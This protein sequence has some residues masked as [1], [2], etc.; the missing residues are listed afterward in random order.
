LKP[1]IEEA[2]LYSTELRA[3]NDRDTKKISIYQSLQHS[4]N[5]FGKV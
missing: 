3:Q 4:R 1:T 5:A 2:G